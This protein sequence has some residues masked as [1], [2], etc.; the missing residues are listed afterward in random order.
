MEHPQTRITFGNFRSNPDFTGFPPDS[1]PWNSR[2]LIPHYHF[3]R[4]NNQKIHGNPTNQPAERSLLLRIPTL[5]LNAGEKAHF[6]ISNDI[7]WPWEDLGQNNSKKYIKADLSKGD[8]GFPYA[9]ICK[10]EY[11]QTPT[12]PI[13]VLL[14]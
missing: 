10:T 2:G 5:Q 11:T 6:V 9:L 13:T 12:E 1:P 14:I 7:V 4:S 3:F 8:E